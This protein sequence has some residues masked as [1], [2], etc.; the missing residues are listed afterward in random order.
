MAEMQRTRQER[1]NDVARATASA[2]HSL[3]DRNDGWQSWIN[4]AR[5]RK[6]FLPEPG[7]RG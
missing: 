4:N 3:Q 7:W 1:V 6:S 2:N 5:Q